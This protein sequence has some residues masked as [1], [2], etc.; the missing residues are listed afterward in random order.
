MASQNY[1]DQNDLHRLPGT[2]DQQEGGL[3]IKKKTQAVSSDDQVIFKVPQVPSS[4]GLDKLAAEKRRQQSSITTLSSSKRSKTS[5]FEEID[6]ENNNSH[7]K[8]SRHLREQR[9]ETPSSSRSSHHDFYEKTRSA[10]KHM[11]RGLVYGKEGHKQ[12]RNINKKDDVDDDDRYATPNIRGSR[13]SPSRAEWDDDDSDRRR[14]QWEHPTPNDN[15]NRQGYRKHRD[16]DY[17]N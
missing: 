7:S 14:S 13:E 8:K 5:S 17:Y 4:F 3:I 11:Q 1:D 10:P 16:T 6:D 15:Y 9:I 12:H 2:D